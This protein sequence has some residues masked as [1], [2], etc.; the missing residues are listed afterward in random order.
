MRRSLIAGIGSCVPE[1]EV[2]NDDFVQYCDTSDEW[3]RQRTGIVSRRFVSEG[4]YTT[5]LAVGAARNA[6][7]MAGIEVD[8]IDMVIVATC[9][10]ELTAPATA[11]LVQRQLGMTRGAAFDLNAGCT[12]FIYGM[13]TADNFIKGGQANTVL[14]IG[15]E[16]LSRCLDL[17]DRTSCVLFGD[18]AGAMVVRGANGNGDL[19]D[20]G[21]L[22]THIHS[23]GRYWDDVYLDGGVSRS[24]SAGAPRIPDGPR[25]FRHA[26]EGMSEAY[27]EALE[28]TGL[29]NKDIDFLVPH[30]A[31]QRIIESTGKKLGLDVDRVLS[32]I[33]HHGNTSAASIPL[34]LD[35]TV[36][37][38]RVSEGDMILMV[39][40]GSGLTWGSAI[41]RW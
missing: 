18:G 20:R 14:V 8:E 22:T 34:A 28:A 10:P 36:R 23:D 35:E 26:V 41:M 27:L 40:F 37:A 13:A 30:Q 38:G 33:D 11:S 17:S 16:T 24:Q 1:R 3:I 7:G 31:N 21:I 6:I 9:T 29:G 39:A 19:G 15:A 12:G 25:L 4:E 2:F 5:D 32:T